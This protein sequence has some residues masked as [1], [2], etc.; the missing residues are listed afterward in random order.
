MEGGFY[1][2]QISLK[3]VI[4]HWIFTTISE[5]R[6]RVT[7]TPNTTYKQEP[8]ESGNSAFTGPFTTYSQ[9]GVRGFVVHI[10]TVPHEGMEPGQFGFQVH[11]RIHP[12]HIFKQGL[13]L[14]D[15]VF[16]LV[17]HRPVRHAEMNHLGLE[18][19]AH[20]VIAGHGK[21]LPAQERPLIRLRQLP[22]GFTVLKTAR[23]ALLQ[24]AKRQM[25]DATVNDGF[26]IQK[27]PQKSATSYKLTATSKNREPPIIR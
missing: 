3:G 7:A 26:V 17:L 12:V 2:G 27:T 5:A 15:P 10:G 1:V 24:I 20:Q 18:G 11:H 14:G 8:M 4:R 23:L 6:C 19:A 9:G 25:L 21:H 22:N 13:E 16:P